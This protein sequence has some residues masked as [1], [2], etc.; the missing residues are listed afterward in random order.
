MAHIH[1]VYDSD[2]HFS[3]NAVT[4]VLKNESSS[5][6]TL[7][8]GD[9]GCERFTFQIPRTIEGHDMSLCNKVEVQFINID[10]KTK[11]ENKGLYELDD[12]D[13]SP[14]GD[15]VVICSW[16]IKR[17]ATKFAG[18]LAFLLVF[19][20]EDADGIIDY[21]WHTLPYTGIYVSSGINAD[22]TFEDDYCDVIERWK[23]SV[24]DELAA[25]LRVVADE[26]KDEVAAWEKDASDNVVAAMTEFSKGW[27]ATL[28]V[29]R[30]RI[31]E[32]AAMRSTGGALSYDIN[33]TTSTREEVTGTVTSNGASAVISLTV[34]GGPLASGSQRFIPLDLPV[35]LT[36]IGKIFLTGTVAEWGF[37]R[38]EAVLLPSGNRGATLQITNID[39][40][41]TTDTAVT[42]GSFT[43]TYPLA[44]LILPELTDIRVGYDG[45]VHANAGNATRAAQGMAA[46]AADKVADI[47]KTANALKATA[48]GEVV[49][50]DDV[51]P[52]EHTAKVKVSGKNLFDISQIENTV[53]ITNNGD[54]SLTIAANQ[55]AASTQR[56]C[57]LCPTLRDG[58]TVSFSME[59]TSVKCKYLYFVDT[60]TIWNSGTS[61]IVTK[62]ELNSRVT[63]YGMHP[64][65]TNYGE[66][67]VISN[68]QIELGD[69][70]T[71]YE[72]YIDPTTVTL[73]VQDE[74]GESVATYT[75]A[76]DGTVN[77]VSVSPTMTLY[78]DTEG[79]TIEVECNQDT[80]KAMQNVKEDLREVDRVLA[81]IIGQGVSI[82]ENGGLVI[83]LGGV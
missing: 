42:W 55:Y 20:C 52:I 5:K 69:T 57:Q 30:V 33:V 60:K 18:S 43:G 36:P 66:E 44:N 4:R 2:T 75:P 37:H 39:K 48:S 6:T 65:E 13:I 12:L 64:E 25:E 67:T 63:F 38:F 82:D 73:T 74:S 72:P 70:A 61:R 31:D 7:V 50:V 54:G 68:I 27:N 16:L 83:V 76:A 41:L 62:E 23:D 34:K 79:V 1:S 3:A 28:D 35:E 21:A 45:T 53:A 77:I 22:K 15:D 24:M 29:E 51:S 46:D 14:N 59:T 71:E 47:K 81:E 40:D 17:D 26:M 49:R 80:N 9:H 58:N 19:K 8:Q 10:A 56:L 11:E 32:L 78:S